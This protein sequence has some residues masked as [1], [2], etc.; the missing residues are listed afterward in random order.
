MRTER[1]PSRRA[2]PPTPNPYSQL[3]QRAERSRRSRIS[4]QHSHR[5]LMFFTT[6]AVVALL[7]VIV[8]SGGLAARAG[9][10]P[11]SGSPAARISTSTA[12]PSADPFE[13]TPAEAY[14]VGAAGV[15]IP[16]P[17]AEPGWQRRDV[18]S[19]LSQTRA[20]LIAARLDP[21]VLESGDASAYLARLSP[22]TRRLATAAMSHGEAG[23]GYVTRLASG[24]RLEPGRTPRVSG[25]MS[26]ALGKDRQLVVTANFVWVYALR[27]ATEPMPAAG[28][29]L[30]VL[31]SLE[32]YEW[33]RPDAVTAPDRGLRPG[34]GAWSQFHV[35]CTQI[36]MGLLA[37]PPA[38]AMPAA[39][40]PEAYDLSKKPTATPSV[41]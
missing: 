18:Q 4:R 35:D 19:V 34:G 26:V 41:C 10:G 38:D 22:G 3:W 15:V 13:G 37:L 36:K 6:A 40:A 21:R 17:P 27:G 5:R 8:G 2:A 30:V 20:A 24:F 11:F 16:E 32:S 31:H 1:R 25:G 23:L 29:R 12:S 28:A 7:V 14:P 39:P 9:W 33:Y